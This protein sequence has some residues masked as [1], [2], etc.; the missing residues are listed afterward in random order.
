MKAYRECAQCNGQRRK[1]F[2]D[3]EKAQVFVSSLLFLHKCLSTY[4][5][6]R[7]E[8]QQDAIY[9]HSA[10]R[11]SVLRLFAAS[12]M[13]S[14]VAQQGIGKTEEALQ[15]AKQSF[16]KLIFLDPEDKDVE[17]FEI[18]KTRITIGR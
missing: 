12:K 2:Q 17:E 16:G 13:A 11:K 14:D 15:A 7:N 1:L 3:F 8:L 6:K 4:S 5:K 9:R 18:S 10:D